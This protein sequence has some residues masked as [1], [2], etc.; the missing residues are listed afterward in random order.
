[1]QRRL[2]VLVPAELPRHDGVLPIKASDICLFFS[3]N[4]KHEREVGQQSPADLIFAPSL[5]YHNLLDLFFRHAAVLPYLPQIYPQRAEI[6]NEVQIIA[7]LLQGL[8]LLE[9]FVSTTSHC[10]N[11]LSQVKMIEVGLSLSTFSVLIAS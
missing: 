9:G 1:M 11:E 2:A 10:R 7:S 3:L 5:V 6:L 8:C 4:G